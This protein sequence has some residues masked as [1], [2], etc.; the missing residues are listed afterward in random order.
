MLVSEYIN[1]SLSKT[2]ILSSDR[3]TKIRKS[4]SGGKGAVPFLLENGYVFFM[5]YQMFKVPSFVFQ[6]LT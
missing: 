1:P 2:V 6:I 4:L 5:Y 3:F